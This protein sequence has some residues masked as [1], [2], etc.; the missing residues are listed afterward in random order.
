LPK[1]ELPDTGFLA[2]F[3]IA[4]LAGAVGG[5]LIVKR[6]GSKGK[7]PV[8]GDI[9]ALMP[10][11]GA[12]TACTAL[13]ALN[14]G[15]SEELFFRL[16][17]PLLLIGLFENATL[18]FGVAAVVFGLVHIYQGHAGVIATTILGLVFSVLYLWTQNPWIAAAAH[19]FLDLFGLVIRPTLLRMVK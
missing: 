19:V 18:S 12:E 2:G 9:E 1:P 11:N 16:L 3:S 8:L 5:S 10:R 13:L 17:L 4:I 14:A 15:V 6:F 7:P